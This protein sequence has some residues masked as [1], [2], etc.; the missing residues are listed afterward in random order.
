[1]RQT[2]EEAAIKAAEDY[3]DCY[4]PDNNICNFIFT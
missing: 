3:Y 1:M 4:K 2:L